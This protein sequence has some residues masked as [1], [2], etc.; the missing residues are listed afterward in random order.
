MDLNLITQTDLILKIQNFEINY[1]DLQNKA[2]QW[3]ANKEVMLEAIKQDGNN[4]S[5]CSDSLKNDWDIVF[6]AYKMN[7][8]SL[9]HASKEIRND[10]DK[11]LCLLNLHKNSGNSL[12]Y[13]SESL[14]NDKDI[15][16]L[17]VK[18]FPKSFKHA[19]D[20]LKNDI[21]MVL[22]A[23]QKDILLLHEASE[24]LQNNL[25]FLQILKNNLS[26]EK[27]PFS[28]QGWYDERMRILEILED[29][30]WM[31]NNISHPTTL[32]KAK[33]F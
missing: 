15:V 30:Q 23:I 14:Q 18:K 3:T 1:F 8:F 12:S 31:H 20:N 13:F 32:A 5:F 16:F 2:P 17:S 22:F 4:L 24:E 26:Q 11:M 19:S 33:K 29:E 6:F 21:E 27:L 25:H 28:L 10:K 9:E 7:R